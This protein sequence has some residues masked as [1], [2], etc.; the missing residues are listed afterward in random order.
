M[1]LG[2]TIDQL[3]RSG[4]EFLTV[5]LDT[6]LTLTRIAAD[7]DADG[8]S[9]KRQRNLQNARHAYDTVLRLQE[10]MHFTEQETA[11]LNDK[12]R[13]LRTALEQL[14]EVFDSAA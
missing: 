4:F 9:D 10:K 13:E 2:R 12:L 1:A 7:A 14:G 5:D 6:A 11:E 3:Q 8:E